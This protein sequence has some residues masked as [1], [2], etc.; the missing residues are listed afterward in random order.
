M[1][2]RNARGV[3]GPG[4]V[5]TELSF[6]D[7]RAIFPE[8]FLSHVEGFDMCGAYGD[9]ALTRDLVDIVSYVRAASPNCL[10]TMYTNGGIRSAGWWERL[11]A[12][13][14]KPA[15][16][17][18]AI[19]GIG[20]TNA[21]YRRG[22]DFDKTIENAR[23]FINAGGDARWEFLVFRHN[24]HELDA[25]RKMSADMGFKEFSAKKSARFL[26]STYDYIPEYAD[27]PGEKDLLK[28]PIFSSAGEIIGHLEPPR[29]PALVNQTTQRVPELIEHY[30]SL[31]ALF[32][33][34][35][36]HC[37]VLDTNSVFVG[38]QGYA[39]PCCWT[40]VQATRPGVN[41]FPEGSDMQMLEMVRRLGGFPA[42]DT[43]K[44]GLRA[45]VESPLFAEIE[46][47]WACAS[48]DTGKL[49]VCA[50]ACG[51]KFPAYFD[52][53]AQLDLAPRSLQ[54]S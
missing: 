18:F 53:F 54:E 10:I 48:V 5:L 13:L 42:I 51:T 40:Y 28:F 26:E 14:G 35:P 20:E 1:C 22:V 27:Q 31:D 47:S 4:L 3:P 17:I 15:R 43:K 44:V 30:G 33:D 45:A 52:Q 6:E 8:S 19:D 7:V 34:T 12:A 39:F 38:A 36:I 21:F 49:K 37:P 24:E 16:V 25:C 11:A 2:A 9:P 50:R 23:A 29:D 32:N 46:A 41:G